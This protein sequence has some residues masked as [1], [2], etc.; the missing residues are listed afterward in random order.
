MFLMVAAVAQAADS[1]SAKPLYSLAPGT[2]WTYEETQE[3][4]LISDAKS[5]ATHLI[6][7]ISEETL[8]APAH[9]RENGDTVLLRSTTQEKRES[10]SGVSEASGGSMQILEWRNDNLYLHGFRAWVDGSYSEAMNLYQPPLLF[11]NSSARPGD[12]WTVGKQK[13]MGA[14]LSTVA[15]MGSP[16][17]I[18]VPAGTFS[19]CLKIVHTST[20]DN[21]NGEARV[22]SGNVQDTIWYAKD[23]GVVKEFQ[24]TSI[25]YVNKQ[26][27]TLDREEYTRVLKSYTP[28]K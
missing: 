14:D 3:I 2:R 21:L 17:T 22:E 10:E 8:A 19:N 24:V 9:Y 28:A 13:N 1:P 12:S 6:G 7:T 27:A 26:G 16:E 20:V 23:V 18:T 15:T 25:R 5:N 4:V 11:L